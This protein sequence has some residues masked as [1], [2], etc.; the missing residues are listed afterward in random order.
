MP[1]ANEAVRDVAVQS[2]GSVYVTLTRPSKKMC[3]KCVFIDGT[4]G[5]QAHWLEGEAGRSFRLAGERRPVRTVLLSGNDK[6]EKT[7]GDQLLLDDLFADSDRA[8]S[9]IFRSQSSRP[10]SHALVY[11]IARQLSRHFPGS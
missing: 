1:N 7:P 6:L 11:F 8:Y 9:E 3:L 2:D 4:I 5:F 10:N